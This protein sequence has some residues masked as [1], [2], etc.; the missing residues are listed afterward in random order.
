MNKKPFYLVGAI[1]WAAVAISSSSNA[2]AY[3]ITSLQA[4]GYATCGTSYTSYPPTEFCALLIGNYIQTIKMVTTSCNSGGCSS[5]GSVWVSFRYPAGR[6][7]V[8][9]YESCGDA[10]KT[11]YGYN[12][13]SCAC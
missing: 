10:A 7:I 8:S 9:F 1:A 11:Y 2:S 3:T 13:G 12:L 4:Q 5:P 6:K